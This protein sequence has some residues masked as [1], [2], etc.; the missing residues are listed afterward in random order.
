M[1]SHGEGYQ[2]RLRAVIRENRRIVFARWLSV[3]C[4]GHHAL[5]MPG[6]E[7]L[8]NCS[9]C[10]SRPTDVQR[11]QQQRSAH[12]ASD[13]HRLATAFPR[14]SIPAPQTRAALL[15]RERGPGAD[16][17]PPICLSSTELGM[18]TEVRPGLKAQAAGM[19]QR[20]HERHL[21]SA[22]RIRDLALHRA[23]QPVGA[24]PGGASARREFDM[25]AQR[26]L[27]GSIF[28]SNES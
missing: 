11:G 9:F 12:P 4:C 19:S 17:C 10:R 27:V 7:S 26:P 23:R 28:P 25:P 18:S 15:G 13:P 6:C 24:P 1:Q 16:P 22:R 20:R 14:P 2:E 3:S 8:P 5:A 21:L